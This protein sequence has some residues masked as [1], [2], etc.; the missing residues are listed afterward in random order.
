M[1]SPSCP[2]VLSSWWGM[3]RLTSCVFACSNTLWSLISRCSAQRWRFIPVSNERRFDVDNGCRMS[4]SS[5]SS[6]GGSLHQRS[7]GGV[8]DVASAVDGSTGPQA[9]SSGPVVDSLPHP[10]A[11]HSSSTRRGS[12]LYRSGSEDCS[13]SGGCGDLTMAFN[14]VTSSSTA[15]SAGAGGVVL[16][17]SGSGQQAH[18]Q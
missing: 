5:Y 14:A 7:L 13:S 9:P 4:L 10:N 12:F 3:V 8:S 1:L 17:M 6:I 2:C 18:E 15:A 16:S 11:T